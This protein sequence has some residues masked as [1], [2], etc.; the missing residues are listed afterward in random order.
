MLE[1]EGYAVK[2]GVLRRFSLGG[3]VIAL[4]RHQINLHASSQQLISSAQHRVIDNSRAK[5]TTGSND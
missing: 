5:T 1:N 3:I 4:A 2:I